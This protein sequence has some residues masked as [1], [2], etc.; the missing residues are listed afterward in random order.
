MKVSEQLTYTGAFFFKWR[1]YLPIL[2]LPVFSLSFIGYNNLSDSHAIN[3]LWEIGCF[4]ISILGVSVRV[5]TSGTVPHGTSGRNTRGQKADA[6]N[7]TG[8]YSV[9]R[10]PLYLGNY[11]IVLGISLF[12]HS[13]FLPIVVSLTFILYYERI[14]L[15]E[16]GYL[17]SKF[18][19]EYRDWTEK[20]PTI[21]PRFKNY[22]PSKLLFS[23]KAAL[24]REFYGLFEV[25]AI[26]F[27][28]DMIADLIVN[29]KIEFDIFWAPLFMIGLVLFLVMRTLKKASLLR[30][31]GR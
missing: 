27:G 16:E 31:K 6:L 14:I 4:L 23:W 15:V 26:F 5:L 21:I 2:L 19:E 10:H 28:L 22:Q 3:L 25:I 9:V 1:S 13:F 11:L 8:I 24:R 18:G 29:R 12:P 30:V 17:E 20:I 7:T